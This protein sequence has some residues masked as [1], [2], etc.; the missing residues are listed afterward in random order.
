LVAALVDGGEL[1]LA[2]TAGAYLSLVMDEVGVRED[3]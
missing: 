2:V 3:R 1:V